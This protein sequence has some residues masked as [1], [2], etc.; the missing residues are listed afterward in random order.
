MILS[1]SHGVNANGEHI[2][3]PTSVLTCVKNG[4]EF[5]TLAVDNIEASFFSLWS[6]CSTNVTLPI[7]LIF[8]L[9]PLNPVLI[10]QWLRNDA[11]NGGGISFPDPLLDMNSSQIKVHIEKCGVEKCGVAEA[12][13][14]QADINVFLFR[15]DQVV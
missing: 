2:I 14:L 6:F 1:S 11:A 7:Q 10:R 3:T 13:T 9:V 4:R 15:R 5:K 12:S 8:D